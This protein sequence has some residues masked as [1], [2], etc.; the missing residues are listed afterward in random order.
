MLALE[1]A[2]LTGRYV[3]TAFDDRGRAEWPPHP[4]RLFSAL[5][6]THFEALERSTGERAALEWLEQLG[7]PQVIASDASH[8]DVTTVFVPVNDTSVVSS[9]DDEARAVDEAR[10]A[11]AAARATGGKGAATLEKKLAKAEARFADALKRAVEPVAPG[12]EG[13]DG[14]PRA[15]SLLPDRRIRQPRTFP[16]VMPVEPRIVFSWPDA[17]PSAEQRALLDALAARVVRLGHSSSLVTVRVN[18]SADDEAR[19]RWVPDETGEVRAPEDEATL[20]VVATGQLAALDTT[21]AEQ[22]DVPGRVMPASFQRYVRPSSGGENPV[23]TTAFG[24]DWIVL[25]RVAGPRLPSTRA[26]DVARGVRSALLKSFGSDAPEVLSGHRAP[27]ERSDRTHLAIVP[28]PFVA[29]DYA[30]GSILG[31]ALVVPSGA[32]RDERLAIYRAVDAWRRGD[33]RDG[34]L[35]VHLGRAGVLELA[36]VEDEASQKT[37][38]PQTWCARARRWS[39]A[40]PIALDR[41]PGDLRSSDPRK[42]ARAYAEAEETIATACEHVGLPR[43][44]LVTAM[45]SAPLAGGDKT[46]HFPPYGTGKP[47]IQRVLV[48][49]TITFAEPVEGPILL[50]AGRYLGLGLFRPS[51]NH[52]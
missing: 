44:A 39:S 12:K 16:S 36:V 19:S 10:D 34:R 45:V 35:R 13:K 43:P 29:S 25:R 38:S 40:T 50:G 9:L 30:D 28:L 23:P 21:F 51:R 2:L 27:G 49:A 18:D 4:A 14:P 47:P 33:R 42:E 7:A 11:L 6:A 15:A 41:N 8:R 1:V 26:V 46:R 3:A 31:V 32:A 52:G 48:H 5:V 37:L 22:A 20:R 24:Q 17:T